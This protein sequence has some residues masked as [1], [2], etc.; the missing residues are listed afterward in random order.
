ME[1][2]VCG[3]SEPENI[4]NLIS[5]VKPD[6]M[7]LIFYSKSPRFVSD[8]LA[9]Q[10]SEL[11]I[12]KVG[13]FVNSDLENIL[14]KVADFG[15]KAIQ[16]HGNESPE[17]VQNLAEKSDC[18]I[19]K[20]ISVKDEI[21]WESLKSYLPF[22]SKFLFDTATAVHGGSGKRFDWKVLETYPFNKGFLLSGGLDEE[23]ANEVLALRQQIPQLQG[24]DLNSQFEDAPGIKNIEKLRRFKKRLNHL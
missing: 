12:N 2:K 9:V 18:E 13:V 21:E 14:E 16:L 20:V 22:V 1:V 8:D 17:F 5:E 3:M 15:L 6:W 7:G 19:W 23:S 10:I 4:R 24:V 11:E